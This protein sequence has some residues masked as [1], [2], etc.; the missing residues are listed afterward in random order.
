MSDRTQRVSNVRRSWTE[1]PTKRENNKPETIFRDVLREIAP[2]YGC[3]LIKIPDTIP[4]K[5]R[6][7][8]THKKPCDDILV[9]SHGNYMVEAKYGNN[10]LLPHQK[11]TQSKVNAINGSYY[12]LRKKV[13]KKGVFYTIEQNGKILFKTQKIEKL[14][15]FFKDPSKGQSIML[16][17]ILPYNTKKLLR[18]VRI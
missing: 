11:A 4:I 18:K 15:E 2:L 10:P 8:I 17:N 14:F 9:T 1:V 5:G 16:D 13:L 3:A 6:E 7:I 12:C